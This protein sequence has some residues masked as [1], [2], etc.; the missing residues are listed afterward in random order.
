M[1]YE[2][3][4]VLTIWNK[5]EETLNGGHVS[6]LEDVLTKNNNQTTLKIKIEILGLLIQ[7]SRSPFGTKETI[8]CVLNKLIQ[9]EKN[10]GTLKNICNKLKQKLT[11]PI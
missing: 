4:Q 7:K 1:V 8:E 2:C 11:N 5:L 6:S 3:P 9:V 10:N